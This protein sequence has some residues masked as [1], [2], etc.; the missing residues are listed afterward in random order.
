M[1][2]FYVGFEVRFWRFFLSF[3]SSSL[4]IHCGGRW[5]GRLARISKIAPQI[6]SFLCDSFNYSRA[7]LLYSVHR[8]V[9]SSSEHISHL[10]CRYIFSSGCIFVLSF[11][12][13]YFLLPQFPLF[14]FF[15]WLPKKRW[16]LKCLPS[17]R[18]YSLQPLNVEYTNTIFS[19]C[20]CIYKSTWYILLKIY[21]IVNVWFTAPFYN[22]LLWKTSTLRPSNLD[23]INKKMANMNQ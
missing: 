6:Y 10:V 8:N 4:S 12:P 22:W 11:F 20:T 16:H 2:Y 1:Y 5:R 3:L 18:A 19:C 14:F 13:S 21:Q 7:F 23:E 17:S 15:F 9:V